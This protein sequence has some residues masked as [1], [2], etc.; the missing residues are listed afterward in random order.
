MHSSTRGWSTSTTRRCATTA[1]RCC[2]GCRSDWAAWPRSNICRAE[3]PQARRPCRSALGREL[4]AALA[5][6][7]ARARVRSY[8][9][10]SGFD[11]VLR[12]EEH[13]SELQS[14]MHISYAVF[15]LKKKTNHKEKYINKYKQYTSK[16][17]SGSIKITN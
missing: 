9:A 15:C 12:S 13:T 11:V 16:N 3:R 7:K 14:L 4:F 8:R 1:S 10:A 17:V 6:G 2:A 5:T